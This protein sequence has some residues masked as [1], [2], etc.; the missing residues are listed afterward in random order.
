MI[1]YHKLVRDK[2]PEYLTEKGI[3][4]EQHVAD[5]AEYRQALIDKL[6]EEAAE[7]AQVGAVVELADIM[8]VVAALRTLPEYA[9]VED[10]R[11]RKLAEKGGFEKRFIVKGEK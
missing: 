8:E 11:L 1:R 6:V 7:F 10:E 2:I 3:P 9:S 4:F 5:D